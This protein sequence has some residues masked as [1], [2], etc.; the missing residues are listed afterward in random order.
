MIR[1]FLALAVAG[2]SLLVADIVLG[3]FAAAEVPGPHAVGRM[4]HRIVSAATVAAV[5]GTHA[6]VSAYFLATGR[7]VEEVARVD[8]LP[9]WYVAQSRRNARRPL[10][11]VAGGVTTIAIA[12]GLGV[13]AEAHGA[14]YAAW[15]LGAATMALAFNL[16]SF[17]V[18]YA[19]MVG[20]ARLVREGP[21][22]RGE[23]RA[24]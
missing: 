20:H 19:A 2:G 3:C 1:C 6:T 4:L 22:L 21:G 8:R 14:A 9:D 13:A 5:L 23:G 24:K 16:G 18:E 15:H 17:A 7:R 12:A 11:C 10:P